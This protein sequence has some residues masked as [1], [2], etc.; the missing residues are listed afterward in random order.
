MLD[1]RQ[2]SAGARSKKFVNTPVAYSSSSVTS[3][4]SPLVFVVVAFRAAM[5]K[6]VTQT[7]Q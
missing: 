7:V 2:D 1:S 6:S 3:K 5:E 4:N